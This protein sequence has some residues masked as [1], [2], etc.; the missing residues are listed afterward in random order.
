M[1]KKLTAAEVQA[2]IDSHGKGIKLIG[3][4]VNAQTKTTFQC[5][6]GHQWEARSGSVMNSGC[7]C[8]QCAGVSKVTIEE[9]QERLDAQDKGIK[10]VGTY[11]G[12][13]TKTTF[14]CQDGHQ[15]E[16][17][18]NS[19]MNGGHGCPDCA[20]AAA[21]L[22][23]EAVQAKL[24]DQG[25]GIKLIGEYTNNATKTTF[26]CPD[27]HQWKARPTSVMS[28]RGC[29]DCATYGHHSKT[30]VLVYVIQYGSLHTK[31]GI[32]VDP[33][34]RLRELSLAARIPLML[35]ETFSFGEGH[36]AA[37]YEI[38]QMAHAQFASYHSGLTGFDGA[39]E[40]FDI[41]ADTACEYLEHLGG[42]RC[43]VES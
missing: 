39:S 42:V 18:P 34:K 27:G 8:P 41:D 33:Q 28:G 2:K 11:T 16:T 24:D 38:E 13:M 26:Q 1:S 17:L 5:A 7:G 35:Y 21:K 10:L 12:S 22:T 4:Y 36:G 15:W 37:V 25:K 43:L 3:S 30:G 23:A 31:I 6:E 14:Q 19:V 32:S 20:K 29:P 40:Y 9:I